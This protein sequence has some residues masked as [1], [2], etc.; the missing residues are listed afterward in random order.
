MDELITGLL[1][2]GL[3]VYGIYLL[4]LIIVYV[5][6]AIWATMVFYGVQLAGA[7]DALAELP[8]GLPPEVCW[9]LLGAASALAIGSPFVFRVYHQRR[10]LTA[11]CCLPLALLMALRLAGCASSVGG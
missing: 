7:L 9:G 4:L 10:Q 8:G 2:I 1:I 5:L 3:I 11:L 6:C